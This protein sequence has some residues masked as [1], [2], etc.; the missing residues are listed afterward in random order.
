M[1]DRKKIVLVDDEQVNLDYC[2]AMLSE[3]GDFD[4]KTATNGMT[5]LQLIESEKPD[6]VVLDVQMPVLNG[7]QV[8]KELKKNPST[9]RIPVI[10][11]TGIASTTGMQYNAKDMGVT[12]GAEPQAYIDKPLDPEDFQKKVKN[13]LGL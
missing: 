4:I 1:T 9:E 8:F 6:L 5:G 3:I 7:F 12:L 11:L 2:E 13:L 10:M